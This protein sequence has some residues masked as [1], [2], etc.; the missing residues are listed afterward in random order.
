MLAALMVV[1]ALGLPQDRAAAPPPDPES[2]IVRLEDV[3]VD[4][5]RLEDAAE[6]FVDAVA[7]PV[8]RRGLAR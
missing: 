5:R 3:V 6:A 4:A 8:G 1:A 2:G 7:D